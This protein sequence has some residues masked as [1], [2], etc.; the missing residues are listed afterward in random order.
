MIPSPSISSVNTQTYTTSV[1]Y[2]KNIFSIIDENKVASVFFE[3]IESKYGDKANS[4]MDRAC[5]EASKMDLYPD[6]RIPKEAKKGF[7]FGFR[8]NRG[9]TVLELIKSVE[10]AMTWGNKPAY[11]VQWTSINASILEHNPQ[12]M[13]A[14]D[15]S[16]VFCCEFTNQWS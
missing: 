16:D 4:Y 14:K 12:K 7:C 6:R 1:N 8:A 3:F 15:Y 5:Y 11:E 2:L 13:P 10:S 9:E